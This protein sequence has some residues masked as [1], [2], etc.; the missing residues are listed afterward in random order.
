[1]ST[2]QEIYELSP[3][4]TQEYGCQAQVLNDPLILLTRRA[5][6]EAIVRRMRDGVVEGHEMEVGVYSHPFITNPTLSYFDPAEVQ[7]AKPSLQ[8][9]IYTI[10]P[11]VT[12]RNFH[13]GLHAY[14]SLGNQFLLLEPATFQ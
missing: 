9:S 2:I 6:V 7:L 5:N 14:S 1:L 10:L 4:Q 12:E 3:L 13:N 11:I 8:S